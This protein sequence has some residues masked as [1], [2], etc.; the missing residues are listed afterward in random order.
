MWDFYTVIT[1]KSLCHIYVFLGRCNPHS[2]D[3]ENTKYSW[4]CRC[5]NLAVIVVFSL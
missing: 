2:V 5:Y 1:E 3:S 4:V